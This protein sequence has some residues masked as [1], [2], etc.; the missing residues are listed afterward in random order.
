MIA[1]GMG[2]GSVVG[3]IFALTGAGGATVV[4]PLRLFVLRLDV[5]DAAPLALLA[6]GLSAG[7]GVIRHHC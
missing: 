6:V 7:I 1:G 3:L 2:L 5:T 4:V